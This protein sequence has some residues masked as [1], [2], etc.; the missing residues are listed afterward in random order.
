MAKKPIGMTNI[1]VTTATRDR[2][3]ALAEKEERTMF[4]MLRILIDSYEEKKNAN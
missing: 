3:K 4:V 2:L 1:Y